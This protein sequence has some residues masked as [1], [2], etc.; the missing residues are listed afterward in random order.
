MLSMA[1]LALAPVVACQ[2]SAPNISEPFELGI[3]V[4]A[5]AALACEPRIV[6]AAGLTRDETPLVTIENP[7]A[8]DLPGSE[9]RLVIVA[10]STVIPTVRGSP[11][12]PYAGSRPPRPIRSASGGP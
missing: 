9:R 5:V 1:T 6:S 12:T 4:E 7:S 8:F 10:G 11:L 2:P 3:E